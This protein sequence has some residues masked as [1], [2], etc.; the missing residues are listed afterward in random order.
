[1][2]SSAATDWLGELR[3]LP[4]SRV[5]ERLGFELRRGR[6]MAPCPSCGAERR[7]SED[8]RGPVGIRRDELGWR[9]HRCDVHGDAGTLASYRFLGAPAPPDADGWRRLRA[10]C[11]AL[12][13][14]SGTTVAARRTAATLALSSD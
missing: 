2:R 5:A 10:A 7:G 11:A 14:C 12:D 9:C 4:L 8:R 13:L 6:S 1:M 3:G